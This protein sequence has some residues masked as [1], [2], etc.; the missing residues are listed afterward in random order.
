MVGIEILNA[1][2]RMEN[3]R[4]LEYAVAKS[5]TAGSPLGQHLT[6]DWRP[7][8]WRLSPGLVVLLEIPP[9]I[10]CPH[11]IIRRALVRTSG[12]S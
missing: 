4:A 5:L 1:S 11:Y 6:G 9:A 8:S 3:P 10:R 12:R 2:K 7:S